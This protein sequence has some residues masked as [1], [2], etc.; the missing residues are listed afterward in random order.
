M[1][2]CGFT[3]CYLVVACMIAGAYGLL[4]PDYV[5][6]TMDLGYV[7]I[8]LPILGSGL[9]I[10]IE[11]VCEAWRRRDLASAGVAAWNTYAQ[12]HNMYE[13]A[14]ALPGI[15]EHLG[16]VFD[17]EDADDAKGRLVLAVLLLVL[18]SCFAGILTTAAI[19]RGAAKEAA[20]QLRAEMRAA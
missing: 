17:F 14:S 2:A 20:R 5:R 10:W 11:S 13:A 15:F 1:S 19:L 9:G 4:P 8:I 7:V 12:A 18:A 16:K 3:W 6:A